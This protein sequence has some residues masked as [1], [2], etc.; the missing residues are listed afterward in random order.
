MTVN[1][2]GVNLSTIIELV[3]IHSFAFHMLLVSARSRYGTV[4][5][6]LDNRRAA[7]EEVAGIGN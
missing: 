7:G 4:W 3:P 1:W 2:V 5:H 6:R